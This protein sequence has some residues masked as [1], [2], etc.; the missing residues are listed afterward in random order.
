MKIIKRAQVIK[1]L[2]FFILLSLYFI[3]LVQTVIE[4]QGALN[5]SKIIQFLVD[6]KLLVALGVILIWAIYF[7][8]QWAKKC[9]VL[10]S[11]LIFVNSFSYFISSENKLILLGS[12]FYLFVSFF[13]Y[14]LLKEELG[15]CLYNPGF[16]D[17]QISKINKFDFKVIVKSLS[18]NELHG[19]L[20][21]WDNQACFVYFDENIK[22]VD[23]RGEVE[24]Q[25][26][27]LG[28]SFF[29]KAQAYTFFANAIGF[30]I[31][32]DSEKHTVL[33]WDNFFAI[34]TDRGITP[35]I[36]KAALV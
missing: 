18:G 21:N 17:N 22:T 8:K 14:L 30:K 12:F 28:K 4:G 15:S 16:Y 5:A 6:E 24:I 26:D 35:S 34:I 10:F 36:Q 11:S 31:N 20:T 9:F 7:I 3:Y 23:L 33:H 32:A 29:T 1:N 19:C 13:L 25:V 2:I 27:Y